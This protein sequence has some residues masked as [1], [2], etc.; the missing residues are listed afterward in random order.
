[1]SEM[2]PAC[3]EQAVGIKY[4]AIAPAIIDYIESYIEDAHGEIAEVE[5]YGPHHVAL[6]DLINHLQYALAVAKAVCGA[7]ILDPDAVYEPVC[8]YISRRLSWASSE[9]DKDDRHGFRALADTL[10]EVADMCDVMA[11]AYEEKAKAERGQL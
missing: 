9:Y 1:M 3:V 10:A 5:A 11:C 7:N 4:E 2:Q 8:S 6:R